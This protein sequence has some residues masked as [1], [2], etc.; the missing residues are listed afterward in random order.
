MPNPDDYTVG[1]ICAIRSEYVAA[2]ALL[3]EKHDFPDFTSPNDDNVYVLGRVGKHNVVIAGLPNGEYGECAATGVARNMLHTFHKIR[4][5]LMVG[6]GGGVPSPKHDIRLGDVVVSAPCNGHGGVFQYNYGKTIQ[7]Q[8]F[9][10]T[11]YL[12]QPPTLLRNAV[13]NLQADHELESHQLE[14]TISSVLEKIPRIRTKY[15]RP[16]STTDRLYH[17]HIVHPSSGE[18]A[19]TAVCGDDQ[20]VLVPRA[21]REE[22]EQVVIHY[23]TIASGDELMKD[24]EVRDRLRDEHDV[25]CFEMEAAG[26]MNH[27][28]CLVIRGICDYSDSHKNKDWQGYAAM[29]AAAY[30]KDIL[31]R[32]AP[33]RVEAEKPLRS[34][35]DS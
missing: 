12:N 7:R 16:P 20:R 9:Q 29:T 14:D 34:I 10:Y 33:A 1:W 30:A 4:I 27:F 5:G 21:P 17:S 25:L 28:P 35:I 13:S 15:R 8:R 31:R 26:L 3:D 23:G 18:S 19:C 2:M 22:D 32:I 6:I 24:A 11:R